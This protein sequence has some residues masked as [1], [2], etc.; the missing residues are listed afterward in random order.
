MSASSDGAL[1]WPLDFDRADDAPP[2]FH[3]A[4]EAALA[5]VRPETTGIF[6]MI[7]NFRFNHT[8]FRPARLDDL[9]LGRLVLSRDAQRRQLVATQY[10]STSGER[11]TLTLGSGE[12]LLAPGADWTVESA[13]EG[14]A[15]RFEGWVEEEA[16]DRLVFAR[17]RHMA[18]LLSRAPIDRPVLHRPTL[19][20]GLRELQGRRFDL[21]DL[22]HG[23]ETALQ[24]QPVET[25]TRLVGDRQ[26]ALTCFVLA[27]RNSIPTYWWVD[28]DDRVIAM[29]G[30]LW[31]YVLINPDRLP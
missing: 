27:G 12:R 16:G 5:S 26:T 24:L 11:W 13:A 18:R 4:V 2:F 25:A 19:F 20:F 14:N 29:S 10:D 21:I 15:T 30:I 3:L 22:T 1:P 9:Y 31:T 28:P 6:A 8:G 7:P 23:C 17:L